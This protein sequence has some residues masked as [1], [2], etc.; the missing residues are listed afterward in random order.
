MCN[1]LAS[2]SINSYSQDETAQKSGKTVTYGPYNE[3]LAP[4][5]FKKL[6]LHSENTSPFLTESEVSRELWV[7]HWNSALSVEEWHLIRHD[8]A[9]YDFL[10]II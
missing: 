9:K 7:S 5:S 1:S 4:M 8:G 6:I 3:N 2:S 10:M